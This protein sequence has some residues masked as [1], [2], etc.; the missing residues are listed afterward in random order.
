MATE[1]EQL[2]QLHERACGLLA[3]RNL[4]LQVVPFHPLAEF[5]DFEQVGVNALAAK[6]LE[7]RAP[8][9][10]FIDC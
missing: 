2:M 4:R 7:S 5:S 9:L 6:Y 10:D 1:F 8:A 3:D